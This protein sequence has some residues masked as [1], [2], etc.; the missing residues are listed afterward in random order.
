MIEPPG[1]VVLEVPET[2]QVL[3]L[4]GFEDRSRTQKQLT[5]RLERL[6]EYRDAFAATIAEV[7]GRT[8]EEGI[9]FAALGLP[10]EESDEMT[11]VTIAARGSAPLV[12]RQW[13]GTQHVGREE[14]PRIDATAAL[15]TAPGPDQNAVRLPCG[16][17]ARDERSRVL[18]IGAPVPPLPVFCVQ[19]AVAVPGTERTIVLTFTTVAPGDTGALRLQFGRIA[20]TLAFT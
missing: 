18:E 4:S 5:Q 14:G 13:P 10:S 17:A 3:D 7:A 12:E 1:G 19:Y 20:S 8:L 2:W 9:L 6:G 11:T 16:L 15:D